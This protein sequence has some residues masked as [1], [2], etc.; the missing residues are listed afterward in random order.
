MY[1]CSDCIRDPF[2][3]KRI[4]GEGAEEKCSFCHQR[5]MVIEFSILIEWIDEVFRENFTP[6]EDYP[7]A[8]EYDQVGDDYRWVLFELFDA[9]EKVYQ[10]VWDEL[11][12]S[13]FSFIYDGEL[14]FYE[15]TTN[16]VEIE[17]D[18]HYHESKWNEIKSILLHTTRFFNHSII[19][20]YDELMDGLNHFQQQ[21][22]SLPI[23]NIGGKSED[24]FFFRARKANSK[25][26]QFKIMKKPVKELGPPPREKATAGRMNPHGIPVFYGALSPE[27]CLSELRLSVGETAVVGKFR[28]I[29]DLKV[30]DFTSLNNIYQRLSYFDPNFYEKASRIGFL[31]KFDQEISC[32]VLPGEEALQYIPTQ[33]FVEYLFYH[34]HEKVDGILFTSSQTNGS[35]VNIVIKKESCG[36]L[37]DKTEDTVELE[38]ISSDWENRDFVYFKTVADQKSI[39]KKSSDRRWLQNFFEDEYAESVEPNLEL[40]VNE[41][42][43]YQCIENKNEFRNSPIRFIIDDVNSDGLF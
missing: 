16:Y 14:P 22:E 9:E 41:I 6:G 2:I 13:E 1:I 20:F 5:K 34:F 12:S 10:A 7:F 29:N 37:Q 19:E 38:N 35:G 33:V 25:D 4:Q 42:M 21:G 39:K 3:E 23:R 15:K 32:P 28:L 31:R 11:C 8:V 40:N 18:F 43:L 30:V 17:N 24:V 26:E 27:T 36:L